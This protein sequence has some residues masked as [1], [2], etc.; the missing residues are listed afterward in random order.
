MSSDISY[1]TTGNNKAA[2]IVVT[3]AKIVIP[4]FEKIQSCI[5]SG[6]IIF[7]QIT[8]VGFVRVEIP[9]FIRTYKEVI[10]VVFETYMLL[11][12]TWMG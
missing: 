5:N 8:N 1:K 10:S 12:F 6:P 11:L 3:A 4:I 7:R 9:F 2:I